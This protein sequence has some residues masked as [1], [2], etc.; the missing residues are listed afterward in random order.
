MRERTK[1]RKGRTSQPGLLDADLHPL[2]E[3]VASRRLI[4]FAGGGVSQN[5][6][7]P[8]FRTLIGHIAEGLGFASGN[9][10]M[11]DY[12]VIAEAYQVRHA[13]LGALRSWM[14]TVWHPAGIDIR[15]SEIH[16]LIV[17]L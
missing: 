11:A 2:I 12:A 3:A 10:D 1:R 17:D 9:I 6:G 4:L 5:L 7:L 8:D 15:K 14:D 16:N 13:Q